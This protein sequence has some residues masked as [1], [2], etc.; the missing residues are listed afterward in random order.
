MNYTKRL[1]SNFVFASAL[2]TSSAFFYTPIAQARPSA[3]TIMNAGEVVTDWF[4]RNSDDINISV[5]KKIKVKGKTV[6]GVYN[7][8]VKDRNGQ[9]HCLGQAQYSDGSY[10]EPYYSDSYYCQQ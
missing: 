4:R 2:V 6:T 10:S 7:R 8:L 3:R 9:V 1:I 5:P